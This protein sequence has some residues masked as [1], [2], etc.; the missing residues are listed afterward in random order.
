MPIS[1]GAARSQRSTI[2][3]RG[4]PCSLKNSSSS[5]SCSMRDTRIAGKCCRSARS[6]C[7]P[8]SPSTRRIPW[9]SSSRIGIGISPPSDNGENTSDRLAAL[10]LQP[11][12]LRKEG[13]RPAVLEQVTRLALERVAAGDRAQVAPADQLEVA[14][15]VQRLGHRP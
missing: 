2:S 3:A 12:E 13:A 5:R 10:F 14:D 7:C 9:P 11:G 1:L 8:H 6:T 15:L 4:A